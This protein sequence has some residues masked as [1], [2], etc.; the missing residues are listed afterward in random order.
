YRSFESM[1]QGWTKN[2]YPLVGNSGAGLARELGFIWAGPVILIC[3]FLIRPM[4]AAGWIFLLIGAGIIF[5]HVYRY[6]RYLRRNLLPL[7]SIQYYMTGV[8]LYSAILVASWW[9]TTRGTV[10]WKGRSYPAGTP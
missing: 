10:Q 5:S 9:K 4:P 1:W 3:V 7:F 2:L 6:F 8:L